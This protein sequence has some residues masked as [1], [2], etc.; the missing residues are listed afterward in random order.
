MGNWHIASCSFG[1]DSLAMILRLIDENK[2]LDEVVFYD[3]GMEFE[4]IYK[5]RD[6]VLPLLAEKGIKYTELKPDRPFIYD[7]LEK[8]IKDH[9][10]YGW[11]GG[12]ARWGTAYKTV[13]IDRYKAQYSNLIEYVGIAF[14]E[15][16]RAKG[17]VYPLIEWQMTEADCLKYCYDKGFDWNENG[18]ELYSILDRV[19]CWCCRNKNKEELYNI[20]RFLPN[21]WERLKDLQ[22]KIQEPMKKFKNKKHGSYGNVFDMEKV[23]EMEANKCPEQ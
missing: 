8:P 7:M 17:K 10:G 16:E 15:K 4:A 20:W 2:P 23:F 22:K 5:V 19:S 9:F 3:T 18:I 12:C 1:K 6:K 13:I 21:Y 14:D 11:C